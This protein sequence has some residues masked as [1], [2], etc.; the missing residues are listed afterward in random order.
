MK[1]LDR[2]DCANKFAQNFFNEYRAAI[3]NIGAREKGEPHIYESREDFKKR[4]GAKWKLLVELLQAIM[5]CD[6]GPFPTRGDDGRIQYPTPIDDDPTAMTG[7]S[8]IVIY[9]EIVKTVPSLVNTL[10]LFGI[11]ALVCTGGRSQRA[12]REALQ[13][14]R[15][16]EGSYRVL[17]LSKIG[18]AG[19]NLHHAQHLI[20]GDMVWSGQTQE[21]IIGRVCRPPNA[22]QVYVWVPRVLGTSDMKFHEFSNTK[23]SLLETFLSTY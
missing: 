19:L 5:S 16:P 12:R 17:V 2:L 9:V 13:N 23:Q 7:S 21:Q 11:D 20:F 18:N 1:D 10:R 14:F 4:G 15:D 22:K 6:D 3:G 8:K